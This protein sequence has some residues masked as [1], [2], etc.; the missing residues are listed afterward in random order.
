MGVSLRDVADL[1]GVSVKTVSNVVNGYAHVAPATRAKV[2]EALSRLDYRPNLSA[3]NLRR[4]RT[5]VIALALPELD[6][7]Y[8]AELSRFVID[9]AAEQRWLV[10]IEQT[11][12]SLERE[13]QILDGVRDHRVDGLIFSPIAIGADEL[14]ARTDETALVL[15]GER[16][17]DGPADH[18]AIDNVRAARDVTEHLIGLGRTRV[19]ALGAQD[20]AVSGTAPLRLAGYREALAAHGLGETVVR[21]D[22]Y[23]RADGAA[24]MAGLLAGGDRPDAVFCFND[25]LALGALRAILSRG[26]RVPE[27]IA[28]AGLDDI[29]DGRYST[30][31]LTTVAPDKAELARIAVDLL[32]RRIDGRSGHAP[33]EVRA[34]YRLMARE[35]TLGR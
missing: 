23:R 5:G 22:R 7:P 2:E 27:D 8:F 14:A 15:L 13:R 4:G 35:S 3:R 6:A 1:A 32:R 29:E 10:V 24:A 20:S 30:P 16:I 17:H 33:Q 18:V 19:A 11:D 28:L 25:L 31:T 34:G 21:V 9:A 12:G 26:L